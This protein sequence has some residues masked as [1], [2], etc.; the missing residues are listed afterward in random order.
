MMLRMNW[1]S[2]LMKLIT[3]FYFIL[4]LVISILNALNGIS[5]SMFD[6][7]AN[8]QGGGSASVLTLLLGVFPVIAFILPSLMDHLEKSMIV[9]R[10]KEKRKLVYRYFAF[11]I[12]I[13]FILTIMIAL[14]GIIGA[15]L[16]TGQLTNLWCSKTGSIYFLLDNKN[17]FP[18]YVPHV[19]SFKVWTY[20]LCSRFIAILF[21]CTFLIFLKAIFKKNIYVFCTAFILLGTDGLF[22]GHFSIFLGRVSVQL[23]IWLSPE[24]QLF[25]VIYFVILIAILLLI[26]VKLYNRKEF[27]H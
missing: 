24:E 18:L 9:S 11:S 25:N 13:S 20:L 12:W 26:C 10:I 5:N 3:F 8:N 6:F 17:Y 14:A 2:T 21:I 19:T 1:T 16:S 15:F 27:L 23:N 22:P 4:I 7:L